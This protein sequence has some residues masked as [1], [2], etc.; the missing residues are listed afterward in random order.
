M[1]LNI[2]ILLS[3]TTERTRIAVQ[4]LFGEFV[5]LDDVVVTSSTQTGRLVSATALAFGFGLVTACIGSGD[6]VLSS[7]VTLYLL[8]APAILSFWNSATTAGDIRS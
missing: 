3:N 8:N 2:Y 1:T 4:I 5:D 7:V 6:G